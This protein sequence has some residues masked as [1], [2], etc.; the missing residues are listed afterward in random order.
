MKVSRLIWYGVAGVVA[1]LL[2]ENKS[3]RVKG[4]AEHK[5]RQLKKKVSNVVH[6]KS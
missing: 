2:F 1:G 5:G 6:S 3:L 4:K